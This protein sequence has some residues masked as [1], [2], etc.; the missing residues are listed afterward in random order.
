MIPLTITTP[1]LILRPL[2]LAD[3]P[4]I[5]AACSNPRITRYTLFDTHQSIDTTIA[6]LNDIAFPAYE[7]NQAGPYGIVR[8]DDLTDTVIG[9]IGSMT[10][11]EPVPCEEFGYWLA[12]P[13][14]GQGLITEASQT[15]VDDLFASGRT[16]R[17]QAGVFAENGASI[18]VLEKA[19]LSKDE[20]MCG[21]LE[22]RGV[23]LEHWYFAK[24]IG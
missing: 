6:F 20:K 12:E 7:L 2:T 21:W 24:C 18:R 8:K 22:H 9:C 11:M 4:A 23:E 5:F 16:K 3:A 17:V 14:W 19:G 1:R 13:Y 15:F 10:K